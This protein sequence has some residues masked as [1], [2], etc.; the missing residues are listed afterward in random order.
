MLPTQ[1]SKT[2]YLFEAATSPFAEDE[3]AALLI[4]A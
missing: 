2:L 1:M 3:G 4:I